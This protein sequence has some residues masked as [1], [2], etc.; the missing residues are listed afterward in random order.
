MNKEKLEHFSSL[1]REL[2]VEIGTRDLTELLLKALI[3]SIK[4][5]KGD[6]FDAFCKQFNELAEII[7]N[8]EPKFGILIYHFSKIQKEFNNKYCA[9][10][11][12]KKWKGILITR[13]NQIL[14]ESKD[15]A[16]KLLEHARSEIDVEGKT[17]LIHDNSHTVQDV[18]VH[19]KRKG[20][21]FKV[22]IAEQSFDK[23]HNNIER[24][25]VAKIPFQVVPAY[26]LSHIH[27]DIDMLFF[28]ALTLKENMN[29]VMNTGTHGIIS[30][31]KMEGVPI[32]M[33][34]NARKFSLWKSKTRLGVFM[35]KHKRMHHSKP[36][37]YERIKYSHDRVPAKMFKKIITNAGVFGAAGL[38]KLF[39]EK[40]KAL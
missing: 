4:T 28:G 16:R 19:F 12:T 6:N 22:I 34:I 33:F 2:E 38:K 26:M 8:T 3:L 40:M 13:I 11:P 17:I 20:K 23:T 10:L 25:H 29:F 31:F 30:E 37:E 27:E 15:E 1:F 36:I 18:L 14:I 7:S 5:F 21:K 35:H 24:M 39:K 32:Y 9:T